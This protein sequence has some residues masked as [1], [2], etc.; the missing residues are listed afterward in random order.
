MTDAVIL[1]NILFNPDFDELCKRLGV[2]KEEPAVI[3]RELLAEALPIAKPKVIFQP[4]SLVP[5][6]DDGVL[7]NGTRFDTHIVRTVTDGLNTVNIY[8]ATCG[9]ELEEWSE[10]TKGVIMRRYLADG[11]KERAMRSAVWAMDMYLEKM[12]DGQTIIGMNPGSIID[13]NTHDQGRLYH[14]ISPTPEA[15]G[16]TLTKSNMMKPV[17][18]LSGLRFPSDKGFTSCQICSRKNCP[19]RTAPFDP[20]LY[21]L[22]KDAGNV[23]T[24]PHA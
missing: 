24:D 17:Q 21:Q 12:N 4:V 19:D 22:N 13:W 16:I 23:M 5:D 8:F 14:L 1:D 20:T 6:G 18:S 10:T 11:I 9:T 15:I 2:I 3:L 7:L